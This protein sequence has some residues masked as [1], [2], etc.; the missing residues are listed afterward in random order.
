MQKMRSFRRFPEHCLCFPPVRRLDEIIPIFSQY[1]ML[2]ALYTTIQ[3]CQENSTYFELQIICLRQT[4]NLYSLGMFS[5]EKNY[6]VDE[7]TAFR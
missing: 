5:W 3:G 2:S 6:A 4:I 1:L 7:M